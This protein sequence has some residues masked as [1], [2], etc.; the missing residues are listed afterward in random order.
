MWWGCTAHADIESQT[1]AAML[2]RCVHAGGW[3]VMLPL[4]VGEMRDY[5]LRGVRWMISLYQ[6]GLNGILADQM[7]LGK[8]VSTS[9][10][11][12]QLSQSRLTTE[13]DSHNV[14][15]Y[16]QALPVIMLLLLRGLPA[17]LP[18]LPCGNL[19]DIHQPQGMRGL[20]GI[21]CLCSV[22]GEGMSCCCAHCANT[23][24]AMQI[25]PLVRHKFK[26]LASPQY[27]H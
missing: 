3:Q 16:W 10:A 19:H 9:R 22:C 8:T 4:M 24:Y 26:P 27:P 21:M 17:Y 15:P 18:V 12:L 6:N 20:F 7:G 1:C 25:G 2:L 13:V 14:M 5:Q 23:S 11:L